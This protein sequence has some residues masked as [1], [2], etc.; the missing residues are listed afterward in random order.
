[1]PT[2]EHIVCKLLISLIILSDIDTEI[3]PRPL[4]G[5]A[6]VLDWGGPERVKRANKGVWGHALETREMLP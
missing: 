1:M 2:G 5:V 4:R 3:T 6:R